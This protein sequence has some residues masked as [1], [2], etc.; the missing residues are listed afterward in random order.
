MSGGVPK[1]PINAWTFAQMQKE[2]L[3]GRVTSPLKAFWRSLSGEKSNAFFEENSGQIK[4]MQRNNIPVSTTW[5]VEN[6]VDK[7]W[8][9][10]TFGE[11]FGQA[12]NKTVSESTFKRFMPQLEISLFNDIEAQ[13]LKQGKSQ[14]LAESIA[15]S[16]VKKF[17][18]IAGTDKTILEFSFII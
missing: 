11:N 8:L 12:W 10:N 7:G 4:K 5:N 6:M 17:Y 13:A 1:T 15:S 18:G 3:A 2:F 9:K 16:T 14:S